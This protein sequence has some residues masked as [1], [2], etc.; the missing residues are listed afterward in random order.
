M[1]AYF[2][3]ARIESNQNA[4]E[5]APRL[6]ELQVPDIAEKDIPNQ[7]SLISNWKE[8]VPELL[9]LP[10]DCAEFVWKKSIHVVDYGMDLFLFAPLRI[11]SDG[12]QLGV[13]LVWGTE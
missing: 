1:W 7:E 5:N 2:N 3:C 6:V 11:A 12:Y 13:S 10:W 4:A 8:S 9:Q